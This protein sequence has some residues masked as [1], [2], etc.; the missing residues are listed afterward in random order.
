MHIML[1]RRLFAV[2]HAL[3]FLRDGATLTCRLLEE[4]SAAHS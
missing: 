3:G 2:W 4:T 1:M